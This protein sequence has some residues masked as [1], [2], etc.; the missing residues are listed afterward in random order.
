MSNISD[1]KLYKVWYAM[2]SRCYNVN[3]KTYRHYGGR[4]ITICDEWLDSFQVFETWALNNG[5]EEGLSI[6]RI[7]VNGN[8]CPENCTWATQM[9]QCNNMRRNIY[10]TYL[11]KTQTLAQWA[12][13]LS[14]CYESVRDS[15]L[16]GTFPP[17]EENAYRRRNKTI[18]Y[19]GKCLTMKQWAEELSVPYCSIKHRVKRGTFPPTDENAH[20]RRNKQITYQ[21]ESLTMKQWSEKLGITYN[22]LKNRV[23]RGQFPPKENS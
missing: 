20:K 8:Y 11:G 3:Y 12:R 14:R 4:G 13:E 15:Y 2:K 6:E 21:G 7:D 23:I 1:S 5:Y 19:Q 16:R 10:V 18:E 17:T 9:E 22:A